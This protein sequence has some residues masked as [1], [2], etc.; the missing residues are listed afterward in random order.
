MTLK[1]GLVSNKSRLC[2]DQQW[3]VKLSSALL[4]A[5]D[6]EP[7]KSKPPKRARLLLD[8]LIILL[9]DSDDSLHQACTP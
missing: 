2:L 1:A 5:R 3:Y 8:N 6:R 7:T 4:T 9:G